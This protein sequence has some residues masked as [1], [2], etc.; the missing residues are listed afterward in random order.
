MPWAAAWPHTLS[1]VPSGMLQLY[2]LVRFYGAAATSNGDPHLCVPCRF[3]QHGLALHCFFRFDS[4]CV[5]TRCHVPVTAKRQQASTLVPASLL[6][7]SSHSSLPCSSLSLQCRAT[8]T[9]WLFRFFAVAC[10]GEPDYRCRAHPALL[11]EPSRTPVPAGLSAVLKVADPGHATAGR[12]ASRVTSQ[13]L[14]LANSS[15]RPQSGLLPGTS[16]PATTSQANPDPT[17]LLPSSAWQRSLTA[18]Q[19]GEQAGAGQLSAWQVAARV[20]FCLY[21][22]LQNLVTTSALWARMA[23][24]FDAS[25]APRLFGLLGAGATCGER[26]ASISLTS[27]SLNISHCCQRCLTTTP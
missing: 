12:T 4:A 25:A 15:A 27:R 20:A 16:L 3:G 13:R 5:P 1:S 7:L 26:H 24:T 19:A 18:A 17:N 22:S 11:L 10:I 6:G 14:L 23:D 8:S 9:L 21:V 2:Q